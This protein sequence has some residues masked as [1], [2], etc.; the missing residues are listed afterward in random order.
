MP[1]ENLDSEK[2]PAVSIY[3]SR[4]LNKADAVMTVAMME[5]TGPHHDLMEEV[6]IAS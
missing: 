3:Y 2:C 4:G 5:T 1:E 6:Q